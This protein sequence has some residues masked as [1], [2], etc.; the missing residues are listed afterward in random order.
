VCLFNN[1]PDLSYF[2]KGV[3]KHS[4]QQLQKVHRKPEQKSLE[5]RDLQEKGNQDMQ[6]QV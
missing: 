6:K 1:R 4:Q 5:N 2:C 3:T